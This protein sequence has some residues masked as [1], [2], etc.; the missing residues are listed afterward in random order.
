MVYS[1]R[2]PKT[3]ATLQ[4]SRGN[5]IWLWGIFPFLFIIILSLNPLFFFDLCVCFVFFFF[6]RNQVFTFFNLEKKINLKIKWFFLIC[7]MSEWYN[8]NTYLKKACMTIYNRIIFR[9]AQRNA[10]ELM[11]G[12]VLNFNLT[13]KRCTKI[14]MS[15]ATE[16]ALYFFL[17]FSLN[18][19]LNS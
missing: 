9:R 11:L 1:E 8:T 19:F 18:G 6:F 7:R 17:F 4:E 14:H 16:I 15:L 10:L 12:D 3:L 2:P 5:Y 13:R